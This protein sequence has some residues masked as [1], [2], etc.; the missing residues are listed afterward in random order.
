MNSNEFPFSAKYRIVGERWV[1][2]EA[3][4][5]LLEDMKSAIMAQRQAALGDI[6]VNKA[7]QSVKASPY[8][9]DYIKQTV[10]ARKEANLAKVHL[11]V[12]RMEYYENQGR[13]ANQRTEMRVLGG[14]T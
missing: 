3:A 2:A 8:W 1:N 9:E 11:E 13:E 6:P 4:A 14:T 7:E 5:Q 12:S 10:E